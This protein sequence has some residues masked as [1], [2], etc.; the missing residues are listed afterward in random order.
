MKTTIFLVTVALLTTAA[1]PISTVSENASDHL[2]QHIVAAL[3]KGSAEDYAKLLP[4]LA[5]FHDVMDNNSSVYG[6]YLTDAKEEFAARYE[7][8]IIP[9]AKKSFTSVLEE[10]A[11]RGINWS[12]IKLEKV[13]CVTSAKDLKPVPFTIV[14]SSN[15]KEYR[16]AID[17]A[18]IMHDVWK[19]SSE[20]SLI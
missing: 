15:G 11:R 7:N 20:I 19:V 16:I 2:A 18:F 5:E 4:T 10:G 17:K 3:K 6:E 14:F 13:E 12:Q 8:K 1:L 9:A